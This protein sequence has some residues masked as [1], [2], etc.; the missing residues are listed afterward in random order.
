MLSIHSLASC[1]QP[2]TRSTRVHRSV[3]V[4]ATTKSKAAP[5]VASPAASATPTTET[6]EVDIY[7]DTPLRYMGYANEVGE[8]FTRF[9]PVWGVPASYCVAAT[10]VLLDT[11]DKGQKAYQSADEG[12]KVSEAF[13]LSLETLIWQMLASVFWPG[14]IIRVVVNATHAVV[15]TDDAL[16]FLPTLAGLAAIPLIVRPIDGTVDQLME[17]SIAKIIYGK[18]ETSEEAISAFGIAAGSVAFPPVMF[19]LAGILKDMHI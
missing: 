11:V 3:H 12:E 10:Y 19:T 14:S 2:S 9:L 13:K 7:R 1:R 15:P 16:A 8:A 5:K 6:K 17:N 4:R 18:I